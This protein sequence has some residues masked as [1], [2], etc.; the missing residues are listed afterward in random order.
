M[1][2]E[3]L[4]RLLLVFAGP[5]TLGYLVLVAALFF[6]L[7]VLLLVFVI[8]AGSRSGHPGLPF[9][10]MSGSPDRFT[11]SSGTE[12]VPAALAADI[13]IYYALAVLLAWRRDARR[14]RHP[15]QRPRP[16]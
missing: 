11:G 3:K 10:Y 9:P 7:D 15:M 4:R 6:A 12:F 13:A 5:A 8:G 2:K 14:R 1:K 16:G